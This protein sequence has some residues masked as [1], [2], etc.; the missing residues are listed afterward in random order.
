MNKY[1]LKTLAC[2]F[3]GILSISCGEDYLDIKPTDSIDSKSAV[4]TTR[5]AMASLNGIHRTMYNGYSGMSAA[6]LPSIMLRMNALGDDYVMT[7]AGNGWFNRDYKWIDHRNEQSWSSYFPYLL[8]YKITDNSNV[9]I[10]GVMNA[11]G[12]EKLNEFIKAQ[13]LTY[14]AFSHHYLVQL[15]GKRYIAGKVNSQL[16]VPI[17]TKNNN[18]G[19]ARSTVEEVYAQIIKDL[20]E[21]EALF[22]KSKVK[23]DNKSHFDVSVVYGLK[24]RVYLTKGDWLNA[25]KYSRLAKAETTE[26]VADDFKSGFNNYENKSWIWGAHMQDDQSTYFASFFAFISNNYSSTNIRTN[27]KAINSDLYKLIADTDIRKWWWDEDPTAISTEHADDEW[28]MPTKFKRFP[29]MNRKFHAASESNSVGDIPFMRR[30]EM[31]LID[32]EASENLVS[33]TG[34]AVL[35]TFMTLRNPSYDIS[36][37]GLSVADEIQVQRRIELWGEGFRFLD[38]KR[39][40]KACIRGANHNPTLCKE[41]NI[42]ADSNKWEFMIPKEEVDANP[43]LGGQNPA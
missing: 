20:D 25:Q 38:L 1:I 33:G 31:E 3:M 9:I 23:R 2:V 16:G 34:A 30:A 7:A 19:I 13:A 40:N 11:D 27:P 28:T 17:M 37:N 26:M 22:I 4:S 12:D 39:L 29:Y 10:N 32:A 35:K 15:Y 42:P 18:S 21:A 41:T 5:D 36:A 6:G 24:A 14:R 43:N 8:F